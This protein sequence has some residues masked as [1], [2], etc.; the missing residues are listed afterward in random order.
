MIASTHTN[1]KAVTRTYKALMGQAVISRDRV[2]PAQA[3]WLGIPP[4]VG[5]GAYDNEG[6]GW[7]AAPDWEGAEHR[8]TPLDGPG[9]KG[10]RP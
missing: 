7:M 8:F 10:M 3:D 5:A 2:S 1:A 4:D 9:H 6:R